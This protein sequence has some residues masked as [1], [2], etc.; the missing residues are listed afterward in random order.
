MTA[1]IATI[2]ATTVSNSRMRLIMRYPLSVKARLVNAAVLRNRV[3]MMRYK[4][5]RNFREFGNF[6]EFATGEVRRIPLLGTW[7]N[8]V[9]YSALGQE[10]SSVVYRRIC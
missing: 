10:V 2:M 1:I 6:R 4:T 8:S 3:I 9:E 5:W 7:V